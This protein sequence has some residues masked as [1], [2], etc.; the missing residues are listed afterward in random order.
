M[1]YIKPQPIAVN[2]LIISMSCSLLL[3]RNGVQD[4]LSA[5]KISK[6]FELDGLA[7]IFFINLAF[8]HA[9]WL[10]PKVVDV[11]ILLV[12]DTEQADLA[13]F[14]QHSLDTLD[15]HRQALVRSAV[16][17][18]DRVLHH[19]KPVL[20]QVLSEKGGSLHLLLGG[21]GQVEKHKEPHDVIGVEAVFG[22]VMMGN[23]SFLISP[24]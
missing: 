2:I 15:M 23:V 7:D 11:A 22:H 18:V 13:R 9:L 21:D 24:A 14:G 12:G 19:G 16:A 17:N 20:L 1:S 4:V 3:I 8:A 6:N 5:T 10:S